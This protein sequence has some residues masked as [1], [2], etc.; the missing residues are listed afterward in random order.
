MVGS[1]VI[2]ILHCFLSKSETELLSLQKLNLSRS[3]MLLG[4]AECNCLLLAVTRCSPGFRE[5]DGYRS[6]PKPLPAIAQRAAHSTF[7]TGTAHPG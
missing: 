7:S 6:T 3:L 4:A 1:L 5:T 2:H